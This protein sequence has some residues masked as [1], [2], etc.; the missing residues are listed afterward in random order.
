MQYVCLILICSNSVTVNSKFMN[1]CCKKIPLELFLQNFTHPY[2]CTCGKH[3][4]KY[5]V[6]IGGNKDSNHNVV[7]R[8]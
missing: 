6:N 7:T 8:F 3:M 4:Q 1:A 2:N 5:Q